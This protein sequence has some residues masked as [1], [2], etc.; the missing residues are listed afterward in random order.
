MVA[1]FCPLLISATFVQSPA[2]AQPLRNL[3][4]ASTVPF[5]MRARSLVFLWFL[6]LT[7]CG[8]QGPETHG[9][10]PTTPE[11]KTAPAPLPG[12]PAF[13]V[14]QIWPGTQGPV[15]A[16]RE[17]RAVAVWAEKTASSWQFRSVALQP[18]NGHAAAA[19]DLGQAPENLEP[20]SYT[21]LR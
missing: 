16:A 9:R 10:R 15:V 18:S 14:A 4:P 11:S 17:D 13:L 8:G 2:P 3:P 7:H 5:T 20:V 21:H 1:S 19:I 6:I 12:L